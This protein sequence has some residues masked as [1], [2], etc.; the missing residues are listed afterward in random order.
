M[1]FPGEVFNFF[2]MWLTHEVGRK[3]T[4]GD[5]FFFVFSEGTDAKRRGWAG[6]QVTKNK[7]GKKMRWFKRG[8][9]VCTYFH[10]CCSPPFLTVL[11]VSFFPDGQRRKTKVINAV[12]FLCLLL[13][14]GFFL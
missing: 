1:P 9:V 11:S 4:C 2:L 8:V 6:G 3:G 5:V 7:P 14:L 10:F 13:L 12:L